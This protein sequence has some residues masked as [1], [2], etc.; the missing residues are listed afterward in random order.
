MKPHF[1]KELNELLILVTLKLRSTYYK[2]KVN[3]YSLTYQPEHANTLSL[4]LFC[5]SSKFYLKLFSGSEQQLSIK[6][7]HISIFNFKRLTFFIQATSTLFNSYYHLDIPR[8]ISNEP[9]TN[10]ACKNL[11]ILQASGQSAIKKSYNTEV[12][13]SSDFHRSK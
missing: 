9:Q 8:K 6:H 3:S 1:K 5:T 2:Q 4:V 12:I 11:I 13:P 10:S 7:P